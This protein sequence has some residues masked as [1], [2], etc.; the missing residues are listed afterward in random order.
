M[1]KSLGVR[2]HHG[3]EYRGRASVKTWKGVPIVLTRPAGE[4]DKPL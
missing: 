3:E 2:Q 1:P 4:K